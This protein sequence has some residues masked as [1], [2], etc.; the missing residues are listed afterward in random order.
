MRVLPSDWGSEADSGSHL[1]LLIW[2]AFDALVYITLLLKH[3][4]PGSLADPF[5]VSGAVG[6]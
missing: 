5:G 4:S 3:W 2:Y 1:F 6:V